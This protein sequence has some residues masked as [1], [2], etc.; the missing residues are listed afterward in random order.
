MDYFTIS[1]L[2]K[3][4]NK[5]EEAATDRAH[6]QVWRDKICTQNFGLLEYCA[7]TWKIKKWEND[8]KLNLREMG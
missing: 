6:G 3:Q 7:S 8:V 2:F 4:Q 5:I 1:I